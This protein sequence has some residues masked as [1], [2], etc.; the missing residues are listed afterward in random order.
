VVS[1]D[2]REFLIVLSD[3][4]TE[5]TLHELRSRFAVTHAASPRVVVV[6]ADREEAA[7]LRSL[8]GVTGVF[9]RNVP[10]DV[11][12]SLDESE[13][14]FVAAWESRQEGRE[15]VR[16]GEGLPWDASGFEPPDRPVNGSEGT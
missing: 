14:L 4:R 13:A 10:G 6:N 3:A 2:R 16:P 7:T 12:E 15:K 9:D 5:T 1:E 11:L 8:P